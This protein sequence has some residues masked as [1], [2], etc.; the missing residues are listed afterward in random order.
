MGAAEALVQRGWSSR[1]RIISFGGSTGG[2][3]VG[4]GALTRSPEVF[5]AVVI[6]SGELNPSR[7]LAAQNGANQIAE[8]GDPATAAGLHALAAMD[9]YQRLRPD[10][11]Y[12]PVLL[13]VGLNDNR[14]Q[15]WESGKFGAR[16]LAVSSSGSPVWFRTDEA[17]GHFNTAQGTVA[18]EDAD[19]YAFS[20]AVIKH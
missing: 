10:T 18:L 12:P 3:L 19:Y 1:G 2:I 7:L 17:M 6:Q 15:P 14:V 16:L 4:G 8:L 13:I 9:P 5:G 20:E 11:A